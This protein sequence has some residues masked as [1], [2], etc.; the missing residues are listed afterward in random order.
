[1]NQAFE[2]PQPQLEFPEHTGN[3]H[4]RQLQWITAPRSN[5]MHAQFMRDGELALFPESCEGLPPASQAADS[6]QA[7]QLFALAYDE[8]RRIARRELK[9]GGPALTLSPTTLLHE[10][11]LNLHQ[12]DGLQFPDRQRFL[13]YAARAMR[14]LIIDYAR[15]RQTQRRG[16][17]FEITSLP[18]EVPAEAAVCTQLENLG[19]ALSELEATD[20]RLAQ[21]VDLKYFSGFS[22]VD[23][24]ELWGTSERTVQR[25]WQKA[26]LFLHLCLSA[27]TA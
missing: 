3:S 14:G 2:R 26:R 1:L 16:S 12:R 21:V 10:V 27:R 18:T 7:E 25:D 8:L 24:A 4:R 23:I 17:G 22:F 15:S 6:P 11:Y 20:A 5:S 9:S 13:A 19:E